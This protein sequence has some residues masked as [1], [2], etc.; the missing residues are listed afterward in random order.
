[1]EFAACGGALVQIGWNTGSRR[2]SPYAV[3]VTDQVYN[4]QFK[5]SLFSRCGRSLAHCQSAG[6]PP[7]IRP[8]DGTPRR[9]NSEAARL[10]PDWLSKCDPPFQGLQR[11]IYF[12]SCHEALRNRAAATPPRISISRPAIKS[13]V[14]QLADGALLLL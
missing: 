10:G 1:M 6:L 8:S 9:R 11:I 5:N 14:L 12:P 3:R 13:A 2:P 4:V 7:L